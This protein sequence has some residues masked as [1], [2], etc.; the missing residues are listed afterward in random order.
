M[1][2]RITLISLFL[3]LPMLASALTVADVTSSDFWPGFW[4]G[5][6]LPFRLF[7]KFFMHD[8]TIYD[9][10]RAIWWY[11]VGFLVGVFAVFTGGHHGANR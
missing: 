11:H 6:T 1:T 8:L 5:L 7:L 4:Q 10:T 9:P 2:K 3:L